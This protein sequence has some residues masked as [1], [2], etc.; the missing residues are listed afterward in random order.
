MAPIC[1]EEETNKL[2]EGNEITVTEIHASSFLIPFPMNFIKGSRAKHK[3]WVCYHQVA[4]STLLKT[5][6]V[7]H[8]RCWVFT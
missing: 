4:A 7:Q 6:F 1:A 3:N 8:L 2:K 5:D